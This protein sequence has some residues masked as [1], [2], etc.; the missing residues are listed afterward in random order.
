[1]ND[2]SE[3]QNALAPRC[4]T[5]QG[6]MRRV[7]DSLRSTMAGVDP[8]SRYEHLELPVDERRTCTPL[9]PLYAKGH[10]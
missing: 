6:T 4:A 3:G 1:M 5:D 2:P 9:A 8:L 10:R 7:V